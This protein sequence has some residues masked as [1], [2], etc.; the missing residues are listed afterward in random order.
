MKKYI[1]LLLCLTF[2]IILR[3]Q[4][5]VSSP[6]KR[7]WVSL[8]TKWR[9]NLDTKM[10]SADGIRMQVT[11]DGHSLVKDKEVG[12]VVKS[13]GHRYSFAKSDIDDFTITKEPSYQSGDF[14]V[15]YLGLQGKYN[16]MTL[17]SVTGIT[18]DILVFNN[19]VT[20]RYT[21]AGFPSDYK[22]LEVC[23]TF[24]DD[25]PNAI[26]GTFTGDKALPWRFLLF[27][28][29]SEWTD[30]WNTTYPSNKIVSW[31][32]AL[33]SVSL[34][35]TTNWYA[36]DR[37][38]E[39][40]QSNGVYADFTYK[41]LYAGLSYTPCHE[42]LYIYYNYDFDP[43]LNNI[44][45]I[46]TWDMT[47]RL[48]FNLPI[49]YG[50]DVWSFSPYATATYLALLQHGKV[51]PGYSEVANKKHYLLGLGL[52]VQYMMRERFSLGVAYEYQMFTGSKEPKGRNSLTFTL[53]YG[54]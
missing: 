12:L 54:F 35:F 36:G 16:R 29:T 43:F 8:K 34:G 14:D 44:G 10:V 45:G 42:L 6:D 13:E 48:G 19:G 25:R 15:R 7:V 21:I 37:W 30:E 26:L 27:D 28:G 50:F 47:G 53:G 3:A 18:L 46:H 52:K 41:Y 4:Y 51:H 33:S 17:R 24:P 49:Q 40:S 38:G 2:P 22:I 1:L 9:R 5:S 20:Y 31:K 11:H 32:D 23:N 39:V